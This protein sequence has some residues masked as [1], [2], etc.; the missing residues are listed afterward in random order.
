GTT[1]RVVVERDGR[2]RVENV[3]DGTGGLVNV[4]GNDPAGSIVVL[5]PGQQTQITPGQAPGAPGPLGLAAGTAPQQVQQQVQQ[6]Q[7]ERQQ[8]REQ[9]QQRAQQQVAEAQAGLAAVQSQ[10]QQLVQ[11]ENQL[12]QDILQMLATPTPTPTALSAAQVVATLAPTSTPG[13][14]PPA[15][16]MAVGQV[17]TAP[18]SGQRLP[19]AAT[20]RV[21]GSQGWVVTLGGVPG[22]TLASIVF[23]TT[24]G[25][26][27]I[28]CPA[29]DASGA[30]VCR[31]NTTGNA[32]LGSPLFVVANG[33]IL[34][35]GRIVSVATV[36]PSPT[37]TP[38][39]GPGQARIVLTWGGSPRDLDAHL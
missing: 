23:Q 33:A 11:Q 7:Q 16:A 25:T 8:R 19:G 35:Q 39:L 31:G 5:L 34:A 6:Q 14:P 21:T 4:R 37:P 17:C 18:L 28:L 36:T 9:E 20:G 27:T 15:C 24:A 22:G 10:L 3:P 2:T 12:V 13:P 30:T 29:P 32:R 38:G 1:P 26:E